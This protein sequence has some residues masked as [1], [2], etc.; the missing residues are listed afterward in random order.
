MALFQTGDFTLA[1]GKRS[2]FKI[3]CD[4]L[5]D[6]DWSSLA[7]LIAERSGDFSSVVGIPRGGLK[8]A[9]ALEPYASQGSHPRLV[10][11]DVCTTGGTL[12]KYILPGDRVW[13]VFARQHVPKGVH[14]LFQMNG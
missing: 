10:V 2:T 14:S 6:E 1:S 9:K 11:D 12:Q 8:L 3:E 4:A 5:T 13:V 7:R